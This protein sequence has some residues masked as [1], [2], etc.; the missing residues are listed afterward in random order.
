MHLVL[1]KELVTVVEEPYFDPC[2]CDELFGVCMEKE[3]RST[4]EV[5]AFDQMQFVHQFGVGQLQFCFRHALATDS[6]LFEHTDRRLVQVFDLQIGLWHAIP[7]APTLTQQ[8]L[9]QSVACKFLFG[10]A[11][12]DVICAIVCDSRHIR[13]NEDFEVGFAVFGMYIDSTNNAQ[14][15][16]NLIGDVLLQFMRILHADYFAVVSDADIERAALG[17]R[18][19]TDFFEEIVPPS[20]FVF[21]RLRFHLF[22]S[23][24][25][26]NTCLFSNPPQKYYF[27]LKCAREK[28]IFHTG[29]HK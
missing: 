18:K 7:C 13:F 29:N 27:F 3:S 25:G 14:F 26:A 23:N 20:L 6:I 10:C 22:I 5:V 15:L 4:F 9:L 19:S 24:E 12:T 2:S 28:C 8:E 16:D 11:R 1:I 21:Y 17:V